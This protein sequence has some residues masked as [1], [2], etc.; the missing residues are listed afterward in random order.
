MDGRFCSE[1]IVGLI[2]N[3]LVNNSTN[4]KERTA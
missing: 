3:R 4:R 1:K 2:Y